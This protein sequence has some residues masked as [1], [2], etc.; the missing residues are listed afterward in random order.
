VQAHREVPAH[1]GEHRHIQEL[2]GVAVLDLQS[3]QVGRSKGAKGQVGGARPA[4]LWGL[5]APL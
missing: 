3:R 2:E 5:L 1:N 4:G